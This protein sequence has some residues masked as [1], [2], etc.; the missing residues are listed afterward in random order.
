MKTAENY[1]SGL[2]A[3]TLAFLG[4][5]VATSA[6]FFGV[7]W[8]TSKAQAIAATEC[9]HSYSESVAHAVLLTFGFWT[10]FGT[11]AYVL[12]GKDTAARILL[13]I[14]VVFCGRVWLLSFLP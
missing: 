6:L 5:T 10:L 1:D 3:L 11:G 4:S 13:G 14:G 9:D 8:L 12:K 2:L 7:T